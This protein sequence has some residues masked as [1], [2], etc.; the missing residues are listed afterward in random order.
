MSN[1]TETNITL[2]RI[3][4]LKEEGDSVSVEY[5]VQHSDGKI[6]YVM[7]NVKLIREHG[8]LFY[9]RLLLDCTSQKLEEK[10]ER[11]E[12]EKHYL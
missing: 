5:R 4:E 1:K 8:E 6:L 2:E 9:Q 10:M 12:S 3:K 11:Q 7:G